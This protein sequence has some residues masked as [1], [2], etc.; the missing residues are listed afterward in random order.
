MIA[1]ELVGVGEHLVEV[2]GRY[3]EAAVLRLKRFIFSVEDE[4]A[5]TVMF[6]EDVGV[7]TKVLFGIVDFVGEIVGV[8]AGLEDEG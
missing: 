7:Q 3:A 1:T 2:S 5:L 4:T 6:E 8:S